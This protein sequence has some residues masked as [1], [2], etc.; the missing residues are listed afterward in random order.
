MEKQGKK[1]HGWPSLL[2]IPA[3]PGVPQT[4]WWWPSGLK[5][6]DKETGRLLEAGPVSILKAVPA[7][8]WPVGFSFVPAHK[9]FKQVNCIL[10]K[11]PGAPHLLRQQS[12]SP[13][14]LVA[15]S[16]SDCNPCV[17]LSG[18]QCPP[19]QDVST[20]DCELSTS[21]ILCQVL[22]VWPSP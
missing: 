21:F 10:A 12:L 13:P 17:A 7:Y 11:E 5:T 19:Y 9:L 20:C 4:W 16:V 14:A 8:R 15:P 6:E 2:Y 22:C 1:F 18:V 3:A